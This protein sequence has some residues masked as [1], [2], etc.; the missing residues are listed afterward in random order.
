MRQKQEAKLKQIWTPI[1][2]IE[3]RSNLSSDEF[4]NEYASIGKPV[5]I[6]DEMKD[7][8]ALTKWSFDFFK[9]SKDG[10]SIKREVKDDKQ[11]LYE[12]MTLAD[13][14][15]YISVC[16]RE[17]PLYFANCFIYNFPELLKDYKEPAYLKSW[18]QRLPKEILIKYGFDDPELFV[19]SKGT[20]IGLHKDPNNCAAWLG[21]IYGRKQVLLFTPD[22]EKFMYKGEGDLKDQGEVDAFNPDLEKFPLFAKAK[23]VE[24]ILEPGEILYIPPN[25]WHHVKNIENN[26][27]LGS[28]IVNEF[29]VDLF[30]QALIEQNKFKG[31]LVP[32]LLRFPNLSRIMLAV[33]IL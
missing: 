21:I 29:N 28:I 17:K 22:Q 9:S 33:G 26:I 6:T 30:V 32:W 4:F 14:I 13:Y 20:S 10:K 31:F 25:W 24:F 7:W 2:S 27:S 3:R 8:K 12:V 16:E 11:T 5:I 23:P 18:L 15:D 19:G 1:S